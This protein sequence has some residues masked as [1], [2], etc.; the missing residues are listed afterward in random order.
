[1][2]SKQTARIPRGIVA[3]RADAEGSP[4]VKALVEE[5]NKA[6]ATFKAEHQKQL[7]E[8]KQGTADAIQALKVDKIN[9]DVARLQTAI[10]EAN[11]A[12]AARGNAGSEA[13]DADPEYT[14]AFNAFVRRGEVQASLS[15]GSDADGGYTAPTEWDRTITDKLK[16]V[17]PMRQ[18]ARVQQV[19]VG[20]FSK[21]FNKRG[22]ASGWVGETDS[23]AATNA[24]QFASLTFGVCEMYA[25]PAATQTILDDSLINIAD[26]IAGEVNVEF[27]YQEGKGF[28]SGDDTN[29]QPSGLLTY[30]TG[31]ANAA[32]HPFGA[33]ATVISGAAA[34]I[35]ADA[36][37]NLVY[38]LPS[39]FVGNATFIC[40][41]KT[42]GLLRLL[43]DSQN[44]YLWQ[45]SYAAGQP[46]T[47]AGFPVV[48]VNDMPDVAAGALALA[49]GDFQ[50]GYLI[51]DRVG[52]RMLR[53]PFT[54]KPY[55]SFYTTKRVGGG[56]LNPEAMKVMKV[57]AT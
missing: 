28:I 51:V 42:L 8:V 16:I 15:K 11:I 55:V 14:K 56:V 4:N 19:S 36:V 29:K 39:A 12:L 13:T 31:G 46:S 26:W 10:D 47:L 18:V 48:E 38:A 35:T 54:N 33:I 30:A 40:N 27:A 22:T 2:F 44:R 21:L 1:M 50:Q 6:F 23:R 5:M 41:R 24:S 57:S 49:F 7:D 43:K 34:A 37:L 17:S 3:V 32:K 52:I 25:N 45:P 9:A 53:D 20:A